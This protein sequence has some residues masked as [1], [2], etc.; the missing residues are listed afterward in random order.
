MY[1]EDCFLLSDNADVPFIFKRSKVLPFYIILQYIHVLLG[2]VRY[3]LPNIPSACIYSSL[4][5][6][7][8]YLLHILT[9]LRTCVKSQSK[10]DTFFLTFY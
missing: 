6:K 8:V 9:S 4:P 7:L 5:C 2:D 1:V 10:V 3:K